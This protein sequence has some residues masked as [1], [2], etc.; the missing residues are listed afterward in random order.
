MLINIVV[1]KGMENITRIHP[2]SHPYSMA[3]DG[4]IFSSWVT[5]EGKERI[6]L[7]IDLLHSVQVALSSPYN[8]IIMC[9]SE[10]KSMIRHVFGF[11][12]R[13]LDFL[14]SL[15]FCQNL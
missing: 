14:L 2:E 4:D 6:F 12:Y 1:V 13:L 15:E 9:I 8:Y 10:G 7:S 3:F 11:T 5:K